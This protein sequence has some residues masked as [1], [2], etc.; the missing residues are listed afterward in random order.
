[1]PLLCRGL[2]PEQGF[3]GGFLLFK[4]LGQDKLGLGQTGLRRLP[5]PGEGPGRILGKPYGGQQVG[6]VPLPGL[7]GA[8]EERFNAGLGGRRCLALRVEFA[9]S[10]RGTRPW[11]LDTSPRGRRA[12]V[13]VKQ[14]R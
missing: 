6:R 4:L 12:P 10:Q 9:R 14:P 7:R 8:G 3:L 11:L 13:L 1:M 2:Q 5:K